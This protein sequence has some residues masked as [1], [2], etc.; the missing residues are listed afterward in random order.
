MNEKTKQ[1]TNGK[2]EG[3]EII[4]EGSEGEPRE[5]LAPV[6]YCEKLYPEMMTEFKRLQKEDYETFCK[7][8]MDYGPGNISL[9]TTLITEEEKKMSLTGL[10]IRMNDKVQRLL[11]LVIKTGR[12]PQ[13]ESITDAFGDLS[14]YGIISRVVSSSKWAK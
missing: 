13:N 11:N 9:G 2:Q 12:N 5:Y 10:I 6:E 7:K 8:Q 4:I 3:S 1:Y 14:V